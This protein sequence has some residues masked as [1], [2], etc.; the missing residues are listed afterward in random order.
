M[1]MQQKKKKYIGFRSKYAKI[2]HKSKLNFLRKVIIDGL[3][4]KDVSI[5]ICIVIHPFQHQLL[6]S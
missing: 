3:S 6:Y 5:Q 1:K 4:I 2:P